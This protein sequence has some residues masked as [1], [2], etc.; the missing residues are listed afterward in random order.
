MKQ[1]NTLMIIRY[2]YN[3]HSGQEIEL[4]QLSQK[5]L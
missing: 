4:C 2:S 1:I 3:C 5:Y